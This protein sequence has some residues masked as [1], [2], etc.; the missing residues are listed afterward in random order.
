[1]NKDGKKVG[2]ER[3]E[4]EIDGE[5]KRLREHKSMQASGRNNLSNWIQL[6]LKPDAL[7]N[8]LVYGSQ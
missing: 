7:Q 3:K 1:M 4:G 6:C 5:I 2:K 8:F